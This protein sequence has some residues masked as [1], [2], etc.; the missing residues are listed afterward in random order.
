MVPSSLQ[1][2]SAG[3]NVPARDGFALQGSNQCGKGRV[4]ADKKM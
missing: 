4:V 3:E 2:S 1:S